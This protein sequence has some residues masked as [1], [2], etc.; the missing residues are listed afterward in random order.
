MVY[1]GQYPFE[2]KEI[3]QLKEKKSGS[4]SGKVRLEE[5]KGGRGVSYVFGILAYQSSRQ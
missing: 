3:R 5:D 1:G 2:R 4:G